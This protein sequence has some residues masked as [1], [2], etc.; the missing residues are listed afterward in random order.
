MGRILAQFKAEH[1]DL[2]VAEEL[3]LGFV[4]IHSVETEQ[5][6]RYLAVRAWWRSRGVDP[7]PGVSRPCPLWRRIG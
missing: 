4:A 5:E 3:P 7:R 1:G 2:T 6:P